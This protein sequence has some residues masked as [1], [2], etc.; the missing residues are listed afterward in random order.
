[1]LLLLLLLLLLGLLLS[2]CA[3]D[4]AGNHC[5]IAAAWLRLLCSLQCLLRCSLLLLL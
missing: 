4:R 2:C 5:R 3:G 1:L